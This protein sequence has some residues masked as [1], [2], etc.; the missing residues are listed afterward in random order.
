MSGALFI[1]Y[2]KQTRD[3]LTET[4]ELHSDRYAVDTE[5]PKTNRGKKQVR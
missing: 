5:K 3:C 2:T 1:I 4:F